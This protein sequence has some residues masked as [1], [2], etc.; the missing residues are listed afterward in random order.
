MTKLPES[1]LT[2][3]YVAE[4]AYIGHQ[5]RSRACM[6]CRFFK[7][8]SLSIYSKCLHGG[9]RYAD[10][11]RTLRC[12]GDFWEAKPKGIWESFWEWVF[13]KR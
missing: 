4:A 11:Y 6:D 5:L 3:A 9:G 12:R 13:R 2:A 10:S 8:D 7:Q 1:L